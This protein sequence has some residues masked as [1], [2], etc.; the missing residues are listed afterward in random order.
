MTNYSKTLLYNVK[1]RKRVDAMKWNLLQKEQRTMLSEYGKRRLVLYADT[2]EELAG[3]FERDMSF[4]TK[5]SGLQLYLLKTKQEQSILLADQL[6]ETANIIKD[7]ANETYATSN[8]LM[9]LQKKIERELRDNNLLIQNLYVVEIDEHMEIGMEV[10]AKKE[11]IFYTDE[12]ADYLS[13]ICDRKLKQHEDNP[14]YVQ[15]EPRMLIFEEEVN[16]FLLEGIARAK[17][18]KEE[19]SGDSFFM[20]EF[21]RGIYLIALSDGMGSGS[22]AAKESE[23]LLELLEK[24]METGFHVDKSIVLLNT[25]IFLQKKEEHTL[26]LDTCE[27][28]LYQGT[29]RFLK[30]GAGASFIKRGRRIWKVG[31]ESL[32]LGVF[33]K[34]EPDESAYGLESGDYLIMMTDGVLDA[35]LEEQCQDEDF[36]SYELLDQN[37]IEIKKVLADLSFQNPKQMAASIINVAITKAGGH[38]MDDMTV[39]VFGIFANK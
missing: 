18:E 6:T 25:L 13:E 31:G 19:D 38:V 37:D 23:Q 12:L 26:T 5:V 21:A 1:K 33:S 34:Q 10:S 29:C 28:D 24:F 30:Y 36:N 16:Y 17:K 39:L 15:D 7:L 11:E 14:T 4:D 3:S 20:R 9:K 32:P 27:I 8:L 35:F 22:I 2:L